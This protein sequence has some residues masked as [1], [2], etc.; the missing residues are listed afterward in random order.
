M[1]KPQGKAPAGWYDAPEIQGAYQFWNGKFWTKHKLSK[2]EQLPETLPAPVEKSIWELV[3][4]TLLNTF[5]Y[6]GRASRREYWWFQ[7]FHLFVIGLSAV[8]F[9][10]AGALQFI[11][12]M[13]VW[14][15]IPTQVAV[16]IRRCHDSNRRGWWYFIPLGNIIVMFDDSDPFANRFGEPSN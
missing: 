11:P 13:F 1:E 5:N 6:R 7:A 16:Y 9:A 4:H 12:A 8:I 3:S 10:D 15:L 2:G 14:G